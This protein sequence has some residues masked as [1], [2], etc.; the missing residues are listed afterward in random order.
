MAAGREDPAEHWLSH[1][2][3]RDERGPMP[4]VR[5]SRS[6]IKPPQ[7]AR[8]GDPTVAD[9]RWCAGAEGLGERGPNVTPLAS[10][11]ARLCVVGRPLPHD[12]EQSNC[13]GQAQQDEAAAASL[14][15]RQSAPAPP[16]GPFLIKRRATGRDRQRPCLA[17]CLDVCDH[18]RQQRFV[19]GWVTWPMCWTKYQSP[20]PPSQGTS[21]PRRLRSSLT[22]FKRLCACMVGCTVRTRSPSQFAGRLEEGG[23]L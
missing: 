19:Q 6:D 1:S 3:L 9:T 12:L 20:R 8:T 5:S 4:Y 22:H 17:A 16:S 18:Q 21:H 2:P 15:R 23:T 13:A 14:S 7:K 11:F 10:R